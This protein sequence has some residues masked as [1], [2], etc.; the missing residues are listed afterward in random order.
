MKFRTRASV[1]LVTGILALSALNSGIVAATTGRIRLAGSTPGWAQAANVKGSVSASA[2]VGFRVYL[3]WRNPAAAAALARAVSDP[4]SSSYG[5]F[6]TPAQFRLKFAPTQAQVGAVQAWLKARGFTVDYTPTNNHY[7]AAEGTY[8]QAAA[9]FA[10]TFKTYSVKGKTVRA[11]ATALS[12]PSNLTGVTA[13]LG[14]DDSAMFIHT[15]RVTDAPPSAGFRNA[16]PCSTY[17]AEKT[18]A[19]DPAPQGQ[20]LP[21][22]YGSDQ[23]Y[24]VCGYTPDQ[25]RGAYGVTGS[26]LDGSGVTVAVIDAYASPTIVSDV[27]RFSAD[28]GLPSVTGLLTQIVAP[29]T[30]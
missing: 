22:V 9:A 11:P 15:D 28:H 13:V 25:L 3:G 8:A 5:K 7:V 1:G 12:V 6:L 24:A 29:G 2:A 10:T 20:V 14:L 30:F 27:S 4:R 18:T 19:T 16:P 21:D 23:P 17:W 26:G